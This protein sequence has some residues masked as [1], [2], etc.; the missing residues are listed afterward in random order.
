MR[1]YDLTGRR[2]GSWKVLHEVESTR[3]QGQH[4]R[5]LCRCAC[6]TEKVIR[7]GA[8]MQ[9]R[10]RGCRPCQARAQ[11]AGRAAAREAR[12]CEPWPCVACGFIYPWELPR[13]E[14]SEVRT[15]LRDL[16]PRCARSAGLLV[17]RERGRAQGAA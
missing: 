15:T 6:G 4:R 10:S 5:W 11:H 12:P 17:I 13:R 1:L 14:A 8:L 7:A 16:C 9:G 3:G 2:F